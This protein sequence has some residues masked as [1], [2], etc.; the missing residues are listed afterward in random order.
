MTRLGGYLCIRT[1]NALGYPTLAA[2]VIPERLHLAIL[3]HA[4]PERQAQDIFPAHYRCNTRGRLR[5][6]LAA[7]GYEPCVYLQ[8]GEPAY[9][10]F[11]RSLYAAGALWAR[12]A[13]SA[14]R[15]TLFAFARRRD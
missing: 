3:R 13:P 15:G 9:F 12:I 6:V 10:E 14:L 1:P 2:T 11:S 5:D 7:N 8:E 4:Q